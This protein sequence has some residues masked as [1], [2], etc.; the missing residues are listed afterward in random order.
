MSS[1]E[2]N[3]IVQ[4]E[5]D[6]YLADNVMS[7]RQLADRCFVA[8]LETAKEIISDRESTYGEWIRNIDKLIKEAT[9]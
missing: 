9:Q 2:R 3:R 1:D 4:R 5:V 6:L 8:G 7:P